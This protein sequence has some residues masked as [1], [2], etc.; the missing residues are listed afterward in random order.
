MSDETLRLRAEVVDAF[1]GPLR[2]LRTMLQSV[3]TTQAT[4]KLKTGM[5]GATRAANTLGREVNNTLTPALSA[6]GIAGLTVSGI[7]A[8]VGASLR[9]F[10][11]TASTLQLLSRETNMAVGSMRVLEEVGKRFDIAPQAMQQSFRTFAENTRLLRKGIGDVTVFLQSQ[12][13]AVRQ[14]GSQLQKDLAAGLNPDVAYRRAL[15]F[16]RRIRDPIERGMFAEKV[17]GNKQ[18]G[19]LGSEDIG[20]LIDEVGKKLGD[21]PKGAAEAALEFKRSWDDLIT[22]MIRLRDT[23]GVTIMPML[24]EVTEATTRWLNEPGVRDG[25]AKAFDELGK[26]LT[27]TDWTAVG[28]TVAGAFGII[29]SAASNT[30]SGLKTLAETLKALQEGRYVDAFRKLDDGILSKVVPKDIVPFG[31]VSS[32]KSIGQLERQKDVVQQ[33]IDHLAT[34]P[35]DRSGATGYTSQEIETKREKLTAELKALTEEIRKL[36]DKTA[37]P[38]VQQQSFTGSGPFGGATIQRA[39]L[40]MAGA[41]G[42]LSALPPAYRSGGSVPRIP[43]ASRAAP[44][45]AA[46]VLSNDPMLGLIASVEQGRAGYNSSLAN[47][48]LTGG[49]QNLT[50]KTLDEIDQI[51]S[52]MLKHPNN[53]WNS[54]AIGRYQIVRKTLRGL[55][56]QLGL[57]GAEKY[58][59]AMQDRLATALMVQ[60]GR[61]PAGLRNEWEGLR[62][63][64]DGRILGAWDQRQRMLAEGSLGRNNQPSEGGIAFNETIQAMKRK[65]AS[66]PVWDFARQGMGGATEIKGGASLDIN[67][68]NAPPGM[69]TSSSVDGIFKD[70]KLR[71]GSSM[72]KAGVSE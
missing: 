51:Q 49:E 62:G 26:T 53:R 8:G 67:F 70:I 63:V 23:A 41:G 59:E 15:E 3:S 2:T 7:L 48:A 35:R 52:G 47:G 4:D 10:T 30:I 31:G 54:S 6:V 50:G 71:Q 56:R 22:S 38:T 20:K 25:M 33:T 9:A 69:S 46:P 28:N 65:P 17:F 55:R 18:L 39:A 40:G 27:Q 58:D 21:L 64:P 12:S 16:M 1:S 60:R 45:T 61:N 19:L 34:L 42:M 5:E 68:R 66:G 44:G 24:K 11:G 32:N 14:W 72:P 43:L 29:G 37:D 36:R 13:P 57:T